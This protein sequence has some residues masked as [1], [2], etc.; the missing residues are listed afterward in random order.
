VALADSAPV[1]VEPTSGLLPDQAP[2][3]VQEAALALLQVNVELVPLAMV[4]GFAA[5]LTEGAAGLTETLT[6]CEAFPAGPV[7]FS[8]YTEF[9]L[10]APLDCVPLNV[11]APDH[12]P[13]ARQED[14]FCVD[15]VNTVALPAFTVLGSALREICGALA[16]TVTVTV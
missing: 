3:P 4:L 14:A 13:L 2:E 16:P 11:F 15:H 5:T 8:V 7:Q 9:A 10:R 12:A 1:D 6:V